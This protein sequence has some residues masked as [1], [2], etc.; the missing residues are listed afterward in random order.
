M[1]VLLE[2]LSPSGVIQFTDVCPYQ[3]LCEAQNLP[4]VRK[5]DGKALYGRSVH[6]IM[7]IYFDKI[8][9]KPTTEQ[10][11]EVVKEAFDDGKTPVMN[12]YGAR[13]KKI[14]DNFINF[15]TIRLKTW[16]QYKPTFTE[17]YLQGELWPDLPKFRCITDFYCKADATFIDWKTGKIE[18]GNDSMLQGKINEMLLKKNGYPVKKGVFFGLYVGRQLEVPRVTDGWVY[19]ITSSMVNMIKRGMFPK[20]QSG[21]C[22]YC[23]YEIRC[24][25]EGEMSLW[26]GI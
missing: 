14:I 21:L 2:A 1:S 4:Q 20:K 10:I 5:D 3:W 7:V 26:T 22:P 12:R 9:S 8:P 25:L 24:E 23:P 19:K 13:T 15:E 16:R 6:S 17:R 11:K 18:M